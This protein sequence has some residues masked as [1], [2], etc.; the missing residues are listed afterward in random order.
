MDINRIVIYYSTKGTR[1]KIEKRI[2]QIY[3]GFAYFFNI[4][5]FY[6]IH[7][8]AR[9]ILQGAIHKPCGQERDWP[10]VHKPYLTKCSMKGEEGGRKCPK[11]CPHGLWMTPRGKTIL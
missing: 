3:P 4:S 10:N 11:N 7:M 6:V 2:V 9:E 5:F 1:S 8:S